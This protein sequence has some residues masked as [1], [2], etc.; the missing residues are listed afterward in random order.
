MKTIIKLIAIIATVALTSCKNDYQ[1][2]LTTIVNEDG[3]ITREYTMNVDSTSLVGRLNVTPDS[4]LRFD[5]SWQLSWSIKDDSVRRQF[6]IDSVTYAKLKAKYGKKVCD[7]ISVNAAKS[8]MTAD[9]V[10]NETCFRVGRFEIKP[11][12][13][14]EKSFRFFRTSYRYTESYPEV[15]LNLSVPL[16]R[17]LTKEEMGY[18]FAGEPNLVQ[19]LNGIETD[20]IVQYLKAQFT[21]WIAANI[22]ELHYQAILKNYGKVATGAI[23]K[24]QFTA[25]H[26]IL[27]SQ[28][29]NESSAK[30]LDLNMTTWM[31]DKLRTHAYDG[32]LRD[33][34]I[35][36]EVE[37]PLN[38]LMELM[39]FKVD[40]KLQMPGGFVLS[41]QLTGSRLIA[42]GFCVEPQVSVPNIWAYILTLIILLASV[43][44]LIY[45]KRQKR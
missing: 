28:F 21:K 42:G 30:D 1:C 4:M 32:I 9:D 33:D 7:T 23:T 18:W 40:Y 34:T 15:K 16:S 2:A 45:C 29:V 14:L 22:F 38:D 17:Y 26:D 31:A 3:S 8:Y 44:G 27:M 13:R 20:D 43:V 10:A 37:A 25:K 6:P 35:M 19:G 41:R 24:Q 39:M 11:S 36:S 12:I 5:N